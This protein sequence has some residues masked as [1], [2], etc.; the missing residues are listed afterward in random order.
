MAGDAVVSQLPIVHPSGGT[1]GH[2]RDSD[3]DSGTGRTHRTPSDPDLR[4]FATGRVETK[5]SPDRPGHPRFRLREYAKIAY[6][7]E[8]Q[9][10]PHWGSFAAIFR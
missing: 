6:P 10:I 4:E 9:V 1:G 7:K 2:L 5:L 3:G 8:R